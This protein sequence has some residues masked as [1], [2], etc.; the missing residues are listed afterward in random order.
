MPRK[1]DLG[2]RAAEVGTELAA[3]AAVLAETGW[4]AQ[5]VVFH[6]LTRLAGI[7]TDP[8]TANDPE[9]RTMVWEKMQAATKACLA[10][11]EGMRVVQE[12]GWDWTGHQWDATEKT[13]FSL[14][15]ATSP[16]QWMRLQVRYA[17]ASLDAAETACARMTVAA[18]RLGGLG[19]RPIHKVAR[20][21]ARR[22][23]REAGLP[24]LLG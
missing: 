8:A 11:M 24:L 3:T 4:A 6:R 22:L 9:F 17:E 5:T 15:F 21:N 7:L 23:T 18:S 2:S 19:L 20:A 14:C 10:V 1:A 16:E 12:A 13:L